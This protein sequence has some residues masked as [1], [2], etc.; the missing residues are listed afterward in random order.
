MKQKEINSIA[1]LP[2]ES[3]DS[4]QESQE[5][6]GVVDRDLLKRK[7]LEACSK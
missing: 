1:L 7:F 6:D 5:D 4:L 3:Q 2:T